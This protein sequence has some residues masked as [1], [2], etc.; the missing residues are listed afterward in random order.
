[1]YNYEVLYRICYNI[2]C[3]ILIMVKGEMVV[4]LI[5]KKVIVL[6]DEEFED[7][8]LWYLVYCVCEEGVEVYLVGEKKGKVYIGKY[9]VFVEVEYSFD[10]L[11]SL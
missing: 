6:V 11:D 7:L 8:E 4:R 2:S 3:D 10:E 5:G 9:G 1:M